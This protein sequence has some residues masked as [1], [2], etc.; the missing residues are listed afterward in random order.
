MLKNLCSQIFRSNKQ[1]F[2]EIWDFQKK[3]YFQFFEKS[4]KS[5]FALIS[6]ILRS[7]FL[8]NVSFESEKKTEQDRVLSTSRTSHLANQKFQKLKKKKLYFWLLW[9]NYNT[10]VV[11]P[12]MLWAYRVEKTILYKIHCSLYFS[13]AGNILKNAKYWEWGLDKS[14][15]LMISNTRNHF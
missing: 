12:K 6:A 9:K 13:E 7:I 10:N 1:T 15:Y 11:A 2:T 8:S 3:G 14:S 5:Y 4:A